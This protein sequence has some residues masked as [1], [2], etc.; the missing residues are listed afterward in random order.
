M[1]ITVV[2]LLVSALISAPVIVKAVQK[3]NKKK[4]NDLDASSLN[5]NDNLDPSVESDVNIPTLFVLVSTLN[6][7]P[8]TPTSNLVRTVSMPATSILLFTSTKPVNVLIPPTL[9]L[10]SIVAFSPTNI[11]FSKITSSPNVTG[12]SKRIGPEKIT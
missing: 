9:K 2:S 5:P 4:Q 1:L 6:A 12:T 3:A 8:A 10:L 11:L 7:V